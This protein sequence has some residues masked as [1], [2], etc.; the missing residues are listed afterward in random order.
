MLEEISNNGP[1]NHYPIAAQ[2]LI[3]SRRW[4]RELRP[5]RSFPTPRSLQALT[6]YHEEMIAESARLLQ[7]MTAQGEEWSNT[8]MYKKVERMN[9]EA[10]PKPPIAGSETI[11]PLRTGMAL[12]Q[13]GQ[14]QH[15]CVGGYHDRVRS[16]K[17][18][19]YQVLQPERATLSIVKESSGEWTIGELLSACNKQV[20]PEADKAVNDWLGNAQIGI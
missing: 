14:Q 16:G 12:L 20:K 4:H 5:G 1:N 18:Y 10:F 2:E 13:E 17:Y 9:R 8:E 19:I 7:G 3:E 15:N 11:I 6:A